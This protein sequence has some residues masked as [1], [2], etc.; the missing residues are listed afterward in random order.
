HFPDIDAARIALGDGSRVPGYGVAL[1]REAGRPQ[2]ARPEVV[3]RSEPETQC[4]KQTIAGALLV[5]RMLPGIDVA[6]IVFVRAPLDPAPACGNIRLVDAG[7]AHGV[8]QP[9]VIRT[10]PAQRI[11]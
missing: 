10:V 3:V 9:R 6:P 1:V 5:G 11:G 7:L 2:K 8:G 4:A